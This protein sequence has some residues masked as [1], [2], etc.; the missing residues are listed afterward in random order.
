MSVLA[1]NARDR[2]LTRIRQNPELDPFKDLVTGTDES[3][4]EILGFNP[5]IYSAELAKLFAVCDKYRQTNSPKSGVVVIRGDRGSGK[6][7]LLHRLRQERP[8][9]LILRP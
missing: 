2:L 5:T 3:P 4:E 9:D 1:E 8:N 6:T 7:T